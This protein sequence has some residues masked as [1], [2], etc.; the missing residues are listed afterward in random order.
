MSAAS[1]ELLKEI[2]RRIQAKG[3]LPLAEYMELAL[4]HPRFGYYMRQDPFGESGD[5]ITAP[6][7]SQIFGELLGLWC[8]ER[9]A[10]LGSGPCALVELGP[11]RGTLM[12]DVLRATRH[13]PDFHESITMHMVELSPALSQLQFNRLNDKHPRIEWLRSVEELPEKPLLILANEFFDALPIRQYVRGADGLHERLV[14][15]DDA[16]QQLAF[17]LAPVSLSMAKG[18]DGLDMGAVVETST[19]ARQIMQS[20]CARIEEHRGAMLLLDYGY[21]EAVHV[22]TLQAVKAHQFHELLLDPGDA[23]LT[24]YVDFGLLATVA[25]E[26]GCRVA[27]PTSQGH[28]LQSLGGEKRVQKLLEHASEEQAHQLSAGWK[29]LTDPNEMGSFTVMAVQ[30]GIG[31]L[32]AGFA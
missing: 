32:P 27:G 12:E 15:W 29:R 21:A 8:A 10:A 14:D 6:E 17:T 25:K 18:Q 20:L 1:T 30:S 2:R 9:W 23:D 13:V 16:T 11:G 19:A 4:A 31:S 24:A 7:I 28:F 3:P 26:A 5:F 22:D